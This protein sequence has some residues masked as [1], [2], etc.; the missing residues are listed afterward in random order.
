MEVFPILN[1]FR[2]H[3]VVLIPA[4]PRPLRLAL[5]RFFP[6]RMPRI[7]PAH[8]HPALLR[9]QHGIHAVAIPRRAGVQQPLHVHVHPVVIHKLEVVPEPPVARHFGQLRGHPGHRVQ[10]VP[11]VIQRP[12]AALPHLE[13]RIRHRRRMLRIR[14]LHPRIHPKRDIVVVDVGGHFHI[15]RHQ[16]FDMGIHILHHVI[17]VLG[18]VQHVDV[19]HPP[20]FRRRRHVR[21]PRK[22]PPAILRRIHDQRRIAVV[23]VRH[24]FPVVI[25]FDM[26]FFAMH[27][28]VRRDLKRVLRRYASPVR[29]RTPRGG[30]PDPRFVVAGPGMLP[31]PELPERCP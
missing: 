18:V 21:L 17:V 6:E 30:V 29:R 15:L 26:D 13:P 12:N 31:C 24:F 9:L 11:R 20:E 4:R 25:P 16:R 5:V 28:R 22:H 2:L 8:H 1:G 3:P 23:P 10:I 27:I 14:K 7:R 19:G